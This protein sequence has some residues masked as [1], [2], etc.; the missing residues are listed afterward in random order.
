MSMI[1]QLAASRAGHDKDTVYV[2]VGQK[3][4]F[5]YVCDGKRKLPDAPKRSAGNMYSR[6]TSG[7]MLN[8][9]PGCEAAGRC[10]RRKSN[11]H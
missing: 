5:V 8:C 10:I 9:L 11:M 1:G 6:S 4:D 2:I 7:W 3:D